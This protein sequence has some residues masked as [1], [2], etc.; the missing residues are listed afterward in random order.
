[1]PW[2]SLSEPVKQVSDWVELPLLSVFLLALSA[3]YKP[4]RFGWPALSLLALLPPSLW[5]RRELTTR[6]SIGSCEKPALSSARI[7]SKLFPS[8]QLFARFLSY[9]RTKDKKMIPAL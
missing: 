1:M 6:L 5:S 9:L 3:H 2:T 4:L 8:L 7:R